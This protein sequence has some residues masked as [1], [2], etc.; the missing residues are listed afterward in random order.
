MSTLHGWDSSMPLST[1]DGQLHETSHGQ[2]DTS[3][4]TGSLN[5]LSKRAQTTTIGNEPKL[6]CLLL[7]LLLLLLLW[8]LELSDELFGVMRYSCQ[9]WQ[10]R[11]LVLLLRVLRTLCIQNPPIRS[12]LVMRVR[13]YLPSKQVFHLSHALGGN[14]LL[15][16]DRSYCR[17]QPI[18]GG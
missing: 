9:I 13:S 7:P 16:L 10:L 3:F 14:R 8:L 11:C 15:V 2:E 17:I 4:P 12:S 1:R 18:N 5:P 6:L